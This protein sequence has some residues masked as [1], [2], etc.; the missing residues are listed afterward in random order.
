MSHIFWEPSTPPVTQ[1][2]PSRL[3]PSMK[4][5]DVSLCSWVRDSGQSDLSTPSLRF[6]P[7]DSRTLFIRKL[8]TRVSSFVFFVKLDPILTSPRPILLGFPTDLMVS[9]K[10]QTKGRDLLWF[11]SFSSTRVPISSVSN[12]ENS[13]PGS[14]LVS[15]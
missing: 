13:V 5:T 9:L 12:H 14:N 6:R 10:Y 8:V 11:H 2:F 1:D 4:T 7:P 15:G 3:R